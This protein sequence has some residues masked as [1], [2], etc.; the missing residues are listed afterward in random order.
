MMVANNRKLMGTHVN[1]RAA[2]FLGWITVAVMAVA[3]IA[4]FATGGISL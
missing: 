3:S 1:G 4:L 2:N